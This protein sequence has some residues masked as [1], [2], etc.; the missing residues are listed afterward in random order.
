MA[1]DQHK[2][3]S[4]WIKNAS[5]VFII[6]FHIVNEAQCS[7]NELLSACEHL[8]VAENRRAKSLGENGRSIRIPKCS[9][10]GEFEP[11]Q[12]SNE[13]NGTECW[14]VDQYGLEIAG[15]RK[16]NEADVNCTEP[17]SVCSA[18][19]CRMYCPSGF[20]KDL[21]SGCSICQCRDPCAGVECPG[22]L[23]CQ[24]Q[25]V[26]CKTEPCPPIPT[27]KKARSLF[28]LC[29]AG[30]PLSITDTTRPFLCGTD[31][32]KPTC[33]PLYQCLV[34]SGNDYGVCCPASLKI[35]KPG[36]CPK[37]DDVESTNNTGFMCG[38]PCSHDL[39]CPH[40]QKCCHNNGCG[41][42]CRQPFNVTACH[43]ARVLSEIL[44]VNEREGRGYIPQCND[45][46]GMFVN[47]Q[48]SRNG[49]VCWCVDTL[50]GNKIKG[51]MGA[52]NMVDCNDIKIPN[53]RSNARSFDNQCNQNICAA[54]CEYGFKVDHNGCAT[55]ECSDPCEGFACA[56]G[57]HCE[58]AR[59]PQ[60]TSG[61]S[62]CA[63][64][65]ICKPDI[66]ISNPCEIGTPMVNN[67]TSEVVF[68]RLENT[69]SRGQ[70]R[71][72][73]EPDPLE[74][75]KILNN[76]IVCPVNW[77][78]T[79]LHGESRSVCC[80]VVHEHDDDL[81]DRQQ[82]MCE[83]LRD[84][85]DRMEGTEEGMKLAI[86]SPTCDKNGV[87]ESIQ[88]QMKK[89]KV[90]KNEHRRILEEQNVRQMRKLLTPQ[91]RHKRQ[92]VNV[93]LYR[94]DTANSGDRV[95]HGKSN[96]F[97]F[98]KQKL[99][100]PLNNEEEMFVAE[101]LSSRIFDDPNIESRHAKLID[102]STSKLQ[103]LDQP[104]KPARAYQKA[105]PDS[106]LVEI[107]IEDCWCVD[108]F[109]TE[110]PKTRSSNT[111]KIMCDNL[112]ESLECL[113]LTCRMG[114][115]Y[116][117]ILDPDTQCPSCECRDPCDA[118]NCGDGHECRTVEVSC[119]GEYCPSVPACLPRKPGQCPF[120][121]PPG[122]EGSGADFCE[123]E[124][125]SDFHCDGDM[126]CCS[127]GCGTQC[128]KP[129]L[130]TACQHLRAIQ[131]HQSVELG[132]PAKQKY[133]AQCDENDGSW[134]EVQC[135]PDSI[136]WC[137]DEEGNEKIGTRSNQNS[138]N[139]T[140]QNIVEC[141]LRKC[142]PCEHGY[143]ID[144]M[145]CRTCE[146]REPCKE[147][148]CPGG[149]VCELAQ[150]ECT[151]SPCPKLPLCVPIRDSLCTEGVPLK[152]NGREVSCGPQSEA[153]FCPTTHS[154]QLNPMTNKGVCCSK[155]R[156]VCF[157]SLSD[158]CV[159]KKSTGAENNI[160]KWKF[161]PKQNKCVSILVPLS[162]SNLCQS[163][164]LFHSESA[165]KS[166]CPVLSQCERL[167]LKNMLA[168]KR[169][170]QGVAWFSPK[171]D[172]ETGLWSPIQCLSAQIDAAGQASG[173]SVCWC[174]DKKGAPIK[175]SLTR[176]IEPKC[177]H[178]QARRRMGDDSDDDNILADPVMEELIKQM[179][180]LNENDIFDDD[181]MG[182][183]QQIVEKQIEVIST[184]TEKLL[185]RANAIEPSSRPEKVIEHK[186]I[187]ATAT[188]CNALKQS[189]SFPVECDKNG[190]FLP[191]QC[192]G[193][194][195]WC[196][197]S[198]GN[199]LPY[200]TTFRPGA[201]SCMY[202]PVDLVEVELHLNNPKKISLKDV[203]E[204]LK[205]EVK[206]LL[207]YNPDNL[208][209][210]ENVDGSILLRFDLTDDNKIDTA[211]ALEETV[212]SNNLLL[213]HRK[214][215]ADI[216]QSRFVHRN[217]NLPIPQ[218]SLG[219]TENTFHMIIF[220][221]ATGSAFLIS[222]FVVYIMLKRG[223]NKLSPNKSLGTGDKYVDYSSPIFVLSANE[224]I[225]IDSKTDLVK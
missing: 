14:C 68:C 25:E 216:T 135:G 96:V 187:V 163:K 155:T 171:C 92:A 166:V 64:E 89:T 102:F 30:Q 182:T 193:D 38:T 217:T 31:P 139:C 204:V 28:D 87:F 154:C 211:F 100:N 225:S 90:T 167:R 192:N 1:Y 4:N 77:T 194:I 161:S 101:L 12:C 6:L 59:D 95:N 54:I 181:K 13:I 165:C 224:K 83:Y 103:N 121:V 88:C 110:I 145:G 93:K 66:A 179:T 130:K 168:A 104:I 47:R 170:G 207:G 80:P 196:V 111:T 222:I 223:K 44:S 40:M 112:K 174:A 50:S 118:V 129:Q 200:T 180:I 116:G 144:Q 43:Q 178:R 189:A 26:K 114:C 33:P 23:S 60:C 41:S 201:V 115:D 156:D 91:E 140:V 195:C 53:G 132:I 220:V 206:S 5:V 52:A 69:N 65:P 127:N 219:I 71:A 141:P 51:T 119:E 39:E 218:K 123:Y 185:D 72:Y 214:L 106:E 152:L 175:G 159:A 81:E 173:T 105:E 109:G 11:V 8:Q 20:A 78:C 134:K 210:H 147:I 120:L 55:C 57:L 186:Q 172:T 142:M 191:T 184:A 136:C 160:I 79:K 17:E 63:S 209:V 27:C 128:V 199:Q 107:D 18:S 202:T 177:N 86:P 37:A 82:S 2:H 21:K 22:G 46:N 84:F 133:I 117:F 97:D 58:V 188:R 126:R 85:S 148:S 212:R 208:R 61:S 56:T 162:L 149:E 32:G 76:S 176:G 213:Y 10:L 143:L 35:Q 146:C 45:V 198:A 183:S 151:D 42:N 94:I 164:N 113:D 108:G 221:F 29:P 203:Y 150:V 205:N 124:C 169:A 122:N 197:D 70:A 49:L 138:I 3:T 74:N 67:V 75:E 125:R 34:Q 215:V 48:C 16:H 157:E 190:S 9:Q 137:V 15:T 131:I 19:S 153:D 62:L 99:A 98:L 7:E 24:L 73:F 36:S 158:N